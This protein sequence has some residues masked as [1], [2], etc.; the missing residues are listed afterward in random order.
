[1]AEFI[2]WL[3]RLPDHHA[4]QILLGMAWG[5]ILGVALTVAVFATGQTFGQR[6]SAVHDKRTA[7]WS[8]CVDRLAR[9]GRADG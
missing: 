6:C 5:V 7:E 3:F 9:G 2:R 8:E 4:D 1:M